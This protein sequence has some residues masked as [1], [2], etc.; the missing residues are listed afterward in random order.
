VVLQEERDVI[1][2]CDDYRL[3]KRLLSESS[4]SLKQ[5]PYENCD[6]IK[7][8][9]Y[10]ANLLA[11][12]M[13]GVLNLGDYPASLLAHRL[14]ED[15]GVLISTTHLKN[16]SA[17]CCRAEWGA[18]IILNVK[19]VP[20]RQMFNL[21]HELFHLITW[22]LKLIEQVHANEALFIKNENLA[23]AFAAALLMPQQM[24]DIDVRGNKL[25][26]SFVVALARKYR[27]S[28]IAM[29]WRLCYL[30]IISRQSV[31]LALADEDFRQ[32][33][34]ATFKEAFQTVQPN[35]SPKNIGMALY[36]SSTNMAFIMFQSLLAAHR[37]ICCASNRRNNLYHLLR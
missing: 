36:S 7:V 12:R 14:E 2:H 37:V 16:G 27:V 29:L 1:Q 32:L 13:H 19:E 31:D 20:W 21:A 8:D 5:L 24:I 15:Y 25:T 35:D 18:A 23:E 33:D 9:S 10:W 34:Q 22:N 26:Y 28:T 4:P 6:I 3:I 11:D 17:A 30:R